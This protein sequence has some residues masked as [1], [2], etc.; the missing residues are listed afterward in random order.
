MVP[1]VGCPLS[2]AIPALVFRPEGGPRLPTFEDNFFFRML[3]SSTNRLPRERI[4]TE[5]LASCL[6][7]LALVRERVLTWMARASGT[8]TDIDFATADVLITTE[9][10]LDGGRDE[11]RIVARGDDG[12]LLL[13]WIVEVEVGAGATSLSSLS[14]IVG[15][16]V[17]P[18]VS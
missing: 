1:R 14:K 11:L 4:A 9:N 12:D 2:H 13:A 3:W 16:Y 10:V 8:G 18:P 5:L 7:T 6:R 17:V 15:N